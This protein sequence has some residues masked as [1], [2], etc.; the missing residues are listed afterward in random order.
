MKIVSHL[1]LIAALLLYS[2]TKTSLSVFES[3]QQ[4][5]AENWDFTTAFN[6]IILLLSC[7]A[8][9]TRPVDSFFKKMISILEDVSVYSHLV[10]FKFS[11]L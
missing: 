10:M 1:R 6:A 7:C 4:L 8:A 5:R 9:I 11:V 3:L 2:W